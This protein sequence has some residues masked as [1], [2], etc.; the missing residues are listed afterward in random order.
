MPSQV[1]W[2]DPAE[3]LLFP[4]D[5]EEKAGLFFPKVKKT[6]MV[7][8]GEVLGVVTDFFGKQIFEL[9]APLAG[10][11]LYIVATPPITAGEPLAFIGSPKVQ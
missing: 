10:E 5:L 4:A 7:E 3:V 1:T 9:R 2:Y 11:V 6:Q 8:K